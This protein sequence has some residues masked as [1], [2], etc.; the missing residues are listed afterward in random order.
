MKYDVDLHI[1][2]NAS[3]DGSFAP[4][5]IVNM[6]LDEDM[7]VIAITDHNTCKGAIRAVK[8]LLDEKIT[9]IKLIPGIE[10]DASFL[11]HNLHILGYGINLYEQ[12]FLEIEKYMKK[13]DFEAGLDRIKLIEKTFHITLEIEALFS[14]SSDNIITGEVIAEELLMNDRY[15]MLEPLKPYR[16]GG[17]RSDNPFV[18][19]YWDY[20]SQGKVAYVPLELK[21]LDET[22]QIIKSSGGVPVLAHPGNNIHEDDDILMGI[23]KTGVLGIEAISSYHSKSQ[24]DFYLKRG[25]ERNMLVTC[26]TDFHGKTK[27]SIKMGEFNYQFN[28][29]KITENLTKLIIEE[30]EC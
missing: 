14:R 23:L 15:D 7:K 30:S 1:H 6:A 22:V 10:I 21:S 27:P 28:P 26:G 20:C 3:S 4:E 17:N 11:G 9:N 2:T 18:N 8:Y 16:E 19:F 13:I 29:V 24:I 12:R 25:N 5:D